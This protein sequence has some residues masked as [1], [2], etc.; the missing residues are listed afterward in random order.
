MS[1]NIDFPPPV[2]CE[3]LGES[4][5]I[6]PPV[7]RRSYGIAAVSGDRGLAL[8]RYVGGRM[9]CHGEFWVTPRRAEKL[10]LLFASGFHAESSNYKRRSI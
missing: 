3:H 10:H 8:A 2:N 9:M 5:K 6:T 1:T 4:L 7:V